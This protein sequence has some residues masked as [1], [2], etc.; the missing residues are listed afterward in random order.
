MY[1]R[2]P[3][4]EKKFKTKSTVIKHSLFYLT[5]GSFAS[6]RTRSYFPR[7]LKGFL[8]RFE[9]RCLSPLNS[10]QSR[11]SWRIA[12]NSRSLTDRVFRE[13]IGFSYRQQLKAPP[14]FQLC[15]HKPQSLTKAA[16]CGFPNAGPGFPCDWWEAMGPSECQGFGLRAQFR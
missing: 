7:V 6:L 5:E 11:V 8:P 14:G 10:W 15:T 13:K 3:R 2:E 9:R 1:H 4:K 12:A 16:F